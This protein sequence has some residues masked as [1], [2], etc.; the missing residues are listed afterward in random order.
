MNKVASFIKKEPMLLVSVLVAAA[1]LFIT[2][3]SK[4]LLS[5]ID[6]RTL[7]T[8][9]M[10]LSVL[11]GFKTQNIFA[12]L[13]RLTSKI[14]SLRRLTVFFFFRCFSRRCSSQMTCR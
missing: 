14:T 9:F 10:L 4:E 3:P 1:S 7:A 2:P 8:L 12:P 11:E 13:I 5:A 6:W